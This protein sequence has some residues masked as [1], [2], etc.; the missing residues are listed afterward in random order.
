MERVHELEHDQ[1]TI[2]RVNMLGN[3]ANQKM[4]DTNYKGA[5]D[6]LKD[7]IVLCGRCKPLGALEKNL[8]L[9]YCHAGQL[10]AGER[11][12]KIAERLIPEDTSV[13]AALQTVKQQRS[14]VSDSH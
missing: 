8:G 13:E 14:Q 9:A 11:E 7:A 6:D 3:Q 4:Y 1:Q 2:D 5:I 10:G 12:L